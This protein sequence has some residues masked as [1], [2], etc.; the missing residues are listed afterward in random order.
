[1]A[2][3]ISSLVSSR[4]GDRALRLFAMKGACSGH[5]ASTDSTSLVNAG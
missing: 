2:V 3:E 4:A 1:M 5:A